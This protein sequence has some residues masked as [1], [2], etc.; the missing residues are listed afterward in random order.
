MSQAALVQA[1]LPLAITHA[2]GHMLVLDI[3]NDDLSEVHSLL[4][5]NI[6]SLIRLRCVFVIMAIAIIFYSTTVLHYSILGT[7]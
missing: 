3:E 5:Y 7:Y 1:R 6:I 4:Y 2:A